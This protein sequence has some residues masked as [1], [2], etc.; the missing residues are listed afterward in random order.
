M[1][2]VGRCT[3]IITRE[4]SITRCLELLKTPDTKRVSFDESVLIRLEYASR[5]TFVGVGK[6][7]IMAFMQHVDILVAGM[8]ILGSATIPAANSCHVDIPGGDSENRFEDTAPDLCMESARAEGSRREGDRRSTKTGPQKLPRIPSLPGGPSNYT[9]WASTSKMLRRLRSLEVSAVQEQPYQVFEPSSRQRQAETIYANRISAKRPVIPTVPSSW[10]SDKSPT[11]SKVSF[12]DGRVSLLGASTAVSSVFT[13]PSMPGR[14]SSSNTPEMTKRQKA[15]I[16]QPK[17]NWAKLH[18]C[19][20]DRVRDV[21]KGPE[22]VNTKVKRFP[23]LVVKAS[24]TVAE[25]DYGR[26]NLDPADA[27]TG[28]KGTPLNSKAEP[29]PSGCCQ[30]VKWYSREFVYVV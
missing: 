22:V 27:V 10:A 23:A 18:A 3:E 17:Q 5:L 16:G 19:H 9:A 12:D 25:Q 21:V 13:Y 15:T 26:R 30:R 28:S 8:I 20:L 29:R 2:H 7:S 4:L 11:N 14:T 6:S 24:A 1:T